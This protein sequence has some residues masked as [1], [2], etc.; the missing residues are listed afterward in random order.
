MNFNQIF[1]RIKQIDECGDMPGAL[2]QSPG[3]SDSVNMSVNMNGSGAGGIRDLMAILKNIED[4]GADDGTSGD[5]ADTLFG[6]A[7]PE[8]SMDLD[9]SFANEPQPEVAGID[10]VTPTGDD[11][12]SKGEEAEKANGGGNPMGLDEALVAKL[13]NHYDEVKLRESVS[14]NHR[15]RAGNPRVNSLEHQGH[16]DFTAIVD[17]HTYHIECPIDFGS[18]YDDEAQWV[19]SLT[20]F[21]Q[22]GVKLHHNDPVFRA[23]DDELDKLDPQDLG[24]VDYGAAI[25]SA[26]MSIRESKKEKEPEGT[27]SSK[28]HETDGQRIARLAKEKRQAEKKERMRNDFNA[29]MERE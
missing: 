21:N 23:I 18:S 17:G 22:D 13:Q 26:D 2:M 16:G 4:A 15:T 3:Q 28:R 11:M 29:E 14:R 27:Y 5:D 7:E 1:N 8:V 19:G 6:I 20:I 10:A 12:H 9:D 25:D 24:E